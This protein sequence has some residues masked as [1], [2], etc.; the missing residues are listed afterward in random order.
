[1]SLPAVQI[2]TLPGQGQP[3]EEE[4]PTRR[5]ARGKAAGKLPVR[6]KVTTVATEIASKGRRTN[7]GTFLCPGEYFS[8]DRGG[9]C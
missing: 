3:A 1:M 9:V 4:T 6:P 2:P 8:P 5:T 7:K